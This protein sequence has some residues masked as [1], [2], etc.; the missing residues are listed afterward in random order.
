LDAF[1]LL[2]R[3]G[4]PAS[5]GEV[6]PF[7][8]A[9]LAASGGAPLFPDVNVAMPRRG[10]AFGEPDPSFPSSISGLEFMAGHPVANAAFTTPVPAPAPTA[11]ATPASAAA[12]VIMILLSLFTIVYMS[13]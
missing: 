10:D 8:S 7:G 11:T 4:Q 6:D 13:F 3:R 5:S 12:P 2:A 9:P 1:D